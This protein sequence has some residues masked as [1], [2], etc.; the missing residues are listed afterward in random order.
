MLDLTIKIP[1]VIPEN[2]KHRS[3]VVL[4]LGQCLRHRYNI[5]STERQINV[6]SGGPLNVFLFDKQIYIYIKVQNLSGNF[7]SL[8][9]EF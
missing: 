5:Q 8:E 9:F 3:D 1:V 4:L 7:L 6:F 2:T